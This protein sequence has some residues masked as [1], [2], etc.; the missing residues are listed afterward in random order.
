MSFSIPPEMWGS[1]FWNTIAT[2]EDQKARQ[3]EANYAQKEFSEEILDME[4][5]EKIMQQ[6]N[7]EF[8]VAKN[9]L[10]KANNDSTE[11]I[12]CILEQKEKYKNVRLD[13]EIVMQ[14]TNCSR[15]QALQSILANNFDLVHAITQL[16]KD[17]N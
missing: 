3:K 4:K 7:T 14:Q 9:A 10:L 15:D 6:T 17:E 5:I 11:A 1:T 2:H 16:T 12:V 13:V 8:F